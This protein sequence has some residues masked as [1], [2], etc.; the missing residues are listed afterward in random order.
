MNADGSGRTNLS[1]RPT[2][3][4]Y[5]PAWSPDGEKI[6]FMSD[7]DGNG[8]LYVMNA[9]GI[10]QLRLTFN[11]GDGIE[12]KTSRDQYPAWQLL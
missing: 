1:H 10:N 2:S 3:W 6:V 4:E 11:Q 12:P 7:M 8:E 9:D 5:N